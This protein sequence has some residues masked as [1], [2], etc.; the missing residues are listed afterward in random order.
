M[1]C[2]CPLSRVGGGQL[3]GQ[4]VGVASGMGIAPSP[5]A[6]RLISTSSQTRG[7]ASRF[8]VFCVISGILRTRWLLSSARRTRTWSASRGRPEGKAAIGA[9]RLVAAQLME[10]L[11][12]LLGIAGAQ[13]ARLV[14]QANVQQRAHQQ[15][16]DD[17]RAAVPE[18]VEER[19]TPERAAE[20]WRNLA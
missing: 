3:P 11:R 8:F 4:G 6:P 15:Q 10:A 16:H 9:E 12:T 13:W 14:D 17:D 19:P 7:C 2:A 20:G 1:I 18:Q 5:Q